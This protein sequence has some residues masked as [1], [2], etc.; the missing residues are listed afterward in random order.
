[1][2]NMHAQYADMAQKIWNPYGCQIIKGILTSKIDGWNG[3]LF[4][5]MEES[6]LCKH[7]CCKGTPNNQP[8][9]AVVMWGFPVVYDVCIYLYVL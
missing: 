8:S 2:T 1:M 3:E 7:F 5:E 6:L 9:L 4:P